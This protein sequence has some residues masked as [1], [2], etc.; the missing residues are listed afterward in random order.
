MGSWKVWG[1]GSAVG[2]EVVLG[3]MWCDALP[4]HFRTFAAKLAGSMTRWMGVQDLD[5][6]PV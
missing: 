6:K 1:V 2:L 5:Y 3:V 4:Q